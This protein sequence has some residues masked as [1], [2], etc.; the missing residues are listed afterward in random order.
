MK[1]PIKKTLILFLCLF[2]ADTCSAFAG[3]WTMKKGMIYNRLVY[4]YYKSDKLYTSHGSTVDMPLNGRFYD[5]NINWYEEYGIT[6]RL[7]FISSL[8]YK[9]LY[10]KDKYKY[11]MSHGPGEAEIGLRYKIYEG[12]VVVSLQALYKYG[13]LYGEETPQIGNR[14]DDFEIRLL[15]GKS[16]WPFP[17]YCGVEIGYR[18]REGRPADE[19]R[20]LAEVGVDF[21]RYFYGRIKLDGIWGMGNAD[22]DTIKTP[23]P[24]SRTEP[25]INSLLA[26]GT[27]PPVL[28]NSSQQKNTLRNL[29]L[30]SNPTMT[31][32]FN[33]IKVDMTLGWHITEK[34]GCELGFTP[35]IWGEGTAKGN[36]L[37]TALVYQW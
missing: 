5:H 10:S 7:T 15:T 25:D 2:I 23:Q 35:T 29:S 20:Y 26:V 37:S 34:I 11:E 9:W 33:I 8:Y 12:P 3:A 30:P 31:Q 28:E 6:D 1:H 18:I 16:L 14:Q 13:K 21:N 36:T 32:E 4:N 19:I 22:I 27:N 17:G 24:P